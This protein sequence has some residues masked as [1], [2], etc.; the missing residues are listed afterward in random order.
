MA[1]LRFRGLK[2]YELQLAKL[3]SGSTDA[4]KKAVYAGAAV[5]ADA[6]RASIAALP[7]DSGVRG[8]ADNLLDSVTPTQLEGLLDGWGIAPMQVQNGYIQTKLGFDGYNKTRTKKYPNGQP[9]QLIARS[10]ESGTSF[11]RKHPFVAPAVRAS[12]RAAEEKMAQV[13]NAEI[14]KAMK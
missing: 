14:E 2:E 6:V 10:V 3:A 12:R 5:I 8:S 7:V 11:R 13:L 4:A 9:N 1:T